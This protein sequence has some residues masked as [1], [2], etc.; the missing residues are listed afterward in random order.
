MHPPGFPLLIAFVTPTLV[1][2]GRQYF[3]GAKLT[4]V[5][6][7]AFSSPLLALRATRICRRWRD[8]VSR[9]RAWR[10]VEDNAQAKVPGPPQNR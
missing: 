7:R 3:F 2:L 4:S 1:K 9:Q 5:N 8:C 10:A 6:W